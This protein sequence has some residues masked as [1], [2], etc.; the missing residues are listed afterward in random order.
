MALLPR[1]LP[2]RPAL[3]QPFL[4]VVSNRP[5]Q[6]VLPLRGTRTQP[7]GVVDNYETNR[8]VPYIWSV[9]TLFA[10]LHLN[11]EILV[12]TRDVNRDSAELLFALHETL[13]E[14]PSGRFEIRGAFFS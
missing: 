11:Y 9:F 2:Q 6:R 1:R 13:R 5:L 8:F 14:I 10:C 4:S 3:L 12:D 7:R